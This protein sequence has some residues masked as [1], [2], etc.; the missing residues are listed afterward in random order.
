MLG[1]IPHY[2]LCVFQERVLDYGCLVKLR[3]YA[4]WVGNVNYL[5]QEYPSKFISSSGSICLGSNTTKPCASFLSFGTIMINSVLSITV[6]TPYQPSSESG[7]TVG[8]LRAGSSFNSLSNFSFRTLTNMWSFFRPSTTPLRSAIM[9]AIF[10]RLAGSLRDFLFAIS[11]A[12]DSA[13]VSIILSLFWA[14]VVPVSVISK[15][16]STSSGGL[17]SVAPNERK[18]ST[19]LFSP[20]LIHGVIIIGSALPWFF[21]YV[22]FAL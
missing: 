18:I 6:L 10:S 4:S 16:A 11:T 1:D 15:M 7:L 2:C 5:H 12:V 9:S 20:I 22:A 8:L 3:S 17:A 21:L 19:F 13:T 14:S